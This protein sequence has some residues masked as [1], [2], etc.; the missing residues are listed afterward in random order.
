[1][2]VGLIGVNGRVMRNSAAVNS[3][4]VNSAALYFR[5]MFFENNHEIQPHCAPSL[6]L[7]LSSVYIQVD[8]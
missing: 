6:N 1:M 4:A 2:S 3:A 8:L 7:Y 5:I